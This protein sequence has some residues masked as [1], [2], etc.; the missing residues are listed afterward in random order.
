MQYMCTTFLKRDYLCKMHAIIYLYFCVTF[1]F[2]DARCLCAVLFN[3]KEI[4]SD[5]LLLLLWGSIK[6]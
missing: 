6:K 2:V 5:F 4:L 1:C 3:E